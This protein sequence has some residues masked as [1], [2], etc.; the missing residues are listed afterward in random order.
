MKTCVLLTVVA[1]VSRAQTASGGSD[2]CTLSGTVADSATGQAL[3]R[4]DIRLEA[5]G[6]EGGGGLVALGITDGAGRFNLT[7]VEPG[8]YHLQG[9]RNGYLDTYYGAKRAGS[10]GTKLMPFGV[11]AGTVREAD[12]EPVTRATVTAHRLEW[13]GGRRKITKVDGVYTDDLGQYRI[14]GLPPGK[15]YVLATPGK[16]A[17]G[18][19]I[20]GTALQADS[21]VFYKPGADG[22]PGK[23]TVAPE[24]VLP[25]LYPGVQDPARARIIDLEA[26]ARM[27][28][29]DIALLRSRTVSVRGR[30]HLPSGMQAGAVELSYGDPVKGLS[31]YQLFTQPDSDGNFEFVAAPQGAMTLSASSNEETRIEIRMDGLTTG[32]LTH[33]TQGHCSVRMPLNVGAS[34]VEGVRLS[35]DGVAEVKGRITIEGDASKAAGRPA[36]VFD[37]ES[38]GETGVQPEPDLSFTAHLCGSHYDI[39]LAGE[40]EFEIRSIRA[41]DQDV[42]SDG[43]TIA[44]P[45]EIS[46]DVVLAADRGRVEGVVR[47]KDEKPVEGAVVVLVPELKLRARR[48]RFFT[49]QTDQYGRYELKSVPPGEYRI[50][51]WEDV[52]PGIWHDPEFL[53]GLKDEGEA[54]TVAAGGHVVVNAHV[55]VK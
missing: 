45:G 20:D 36:L 53:K 47:D 30:V 40:S 42:L 23:P 52:E 54:V 8:Q 4:V 2:K 1:L 18:G 33:A 17:L 32:V 14:P 43:L 39:Y 35:M 29:V 3:N 38:D 26:G 10:K 19:A 49:S 51:A 7:D 6:G 28:G 44:G 50:F 46:L 24:I 12:G 5:A 9:T 37:Q 15:Y 11:I 41:G 21:I 22:Q 48:D 16:T 34:P 25:A 31:V 55:S 27:T 13:V